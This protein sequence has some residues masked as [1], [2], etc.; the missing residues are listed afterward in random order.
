M[1]WTGSLRSQRE[2]VLRVSHLDAHNATS[3]IGEAMHGLRVSLHTHALTGICLS[4][5]G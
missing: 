5:S 1:S 4:A 2:C 3:L